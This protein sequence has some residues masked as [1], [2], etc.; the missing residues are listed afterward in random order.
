MEIMAQGDTIT[1][2]NFTFTDTS[3]EGVKVVDVNAYGD[4]RGYFMETYKQS[5]FVAGGIGCVFV[6]DNQSSSVR[7]VL[8][9]L[10]F[11]IEHPQ[12]KLVRVVSG[13]VFDVAVDLRKDSATYGK[14]EG[15]VL[16]AENK[17]QFFIPRGFA[18]GFLV[19]SDSAEFCYKCD[20]VYHPGDEGGLMWNDPKIGIEWPALDGDDLFDESELVL[21]DK[22]RRHP[23]LSA[24]QNSK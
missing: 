7:G 1:S 10:H 3:I 23:P 15:V 18:H 14:W 19:L 2:G 8:R 13:K 16:S 4:T 11:Q 22:D 24:L 12:S 21:S 5:D 20:D 6:Q 17:R 9:G